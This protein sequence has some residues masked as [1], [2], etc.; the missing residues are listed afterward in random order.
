MLHNT[1]KSVVYI[2]QYTYSINTDFL[3]VVTNSRIKFKTPLKKISVENEI[4]SL[5]VVFSKDITLQSIRDSRNPIATTD[6][7]V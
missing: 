4:P 5:N 6:M 3:P 2:Y 7:T 1:A